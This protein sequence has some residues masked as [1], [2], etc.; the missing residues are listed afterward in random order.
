MREARRV[1]K[2]F[3]KVFDKASLRELICTFLTAA[4]KNCDLSLIKKRRC[5]IIQ[6]LEA[7][8]QKLVKLARFSF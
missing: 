1:N 8:I 3:K 4:S 7:V 6:N 2:R 5:S